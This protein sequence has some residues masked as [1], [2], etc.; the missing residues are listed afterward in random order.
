MLDMKEKTYSDR[1]LVQCSIGPEG[2][3]SGSGEQATS[4]TRP[5]LCHHL[6]SMCFWIFLQ[7]PQFEGPNYH[8][9]LNYHS[10]IHLCAEREKGF[11]GFVPCCAF[12]QI[13]ARVGRDG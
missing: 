11:A 4:G 9:E 13:L 2:F 7:P 1:S 8:P 10:D 6:Q 3:C 5:D 12:A